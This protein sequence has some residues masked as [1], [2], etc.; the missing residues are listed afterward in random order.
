MCQVV[1][2]SNQ[3]ASTNHVLLEPVPVLGVRVRGVTGRVRNG[4]QGG[5][6]EP[7]ARGGLGIEAILSKGGFDNSRGL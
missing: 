2:E 6:L 7:G 1:D 5:P 4:R 3:V